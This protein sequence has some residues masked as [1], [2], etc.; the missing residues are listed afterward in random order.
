MPGAPDQA[1]SRGLSFRQTPEFPAR[2]SGSENK[3]RQ[4]EGQNVFASSDSDDSAQSDSVRNA[5]RKFTF[6]SRADAD[7]K[8]AP[9]HAAAPGPARFAAHSESP[10]CARRLRDVMPR[11]A[12]ERATQVRWAKTLLLAPG[13]YSFKFR[14]NRVWV[15]LGAHRVVREGLHSNHQL[16]VQSGRYRRSSALPLAPAP[17]AK[18]RRVRVD[19]DSFEWLQIAV[20]GLSRVSVVGHS[21]SYNQDKVYIFG[22]KRNRVFCSDL[23]ELNVET[24][25]AALLDCADPNSPGPVGFHKTVVFG[26]KL[27]VL[28]GMSETQVL[29]DYYSFN[30]H[31][32]LW[33]RKPGQAGFRL[34][35]HFSAVFIE[36][37][38]LVFVFGGYHLSRDGADEV[39]FDDI[40]CL[41]L[42]TMLWAAPRLRDGPRPRG[43]FHHSANQFDGHMLVFGGA[44]NAGLTKTLFD[45]FWTVDLNAFP[46]KLEWRALAVAGQAPSPRFGHSAVR[47]A[48]YLVVH[49]GFARDGAICA[50]TFLVDFDS[51]SSVQVRFPPSS[52]RVPR[53]FH[54]M[55]RA[56]HA[57]YMFGGQR[58]TNWEGASTT[59]EYLYK[60]KFS[61][62]VLDS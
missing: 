44:S 32:L 41:N 33:T 35:E 17:A 15:L 16:V 4:L 6:A 55:V 58:S 49:G 48:R 3:L 12:L 45:D 31:R 19:P 36:S 39:N 62:E 43:R 34:R 20:R 40:G 51:R 23:F 7:A 5:I 28:G 18:R 50:D 13:K 27:L 29:D 24:N 38:N 37:R 1:D 11:D 21:M 60:L 42:E 9:R 8:P 10:P 47:F 30:P 57:L 25:E 54:A 14:V 52:P 26:Q 56:E 59:N 53:V 61:F 46:A 2:S 22:G